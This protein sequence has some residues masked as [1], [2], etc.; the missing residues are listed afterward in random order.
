[1]VIDTF[2]QLSWLSPLSSKRTVR[3]DHVPT[4]VPAGT[5]FAPDEPPM[6]KSACVQSGFAAS[7]RWD[8]KVCTTAVRELMLTGPEF[9]LL[10]FPE[11]ATDEAPGYSP[12]TEL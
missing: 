3:P 1:M 8:A 11:R 2:L 12:V 7:T 9:G 6:A 4:P 5:T 10:K